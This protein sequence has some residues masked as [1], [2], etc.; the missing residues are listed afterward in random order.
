MIVTIEIT[1]VQPQ[2]VLGIAFKS[3]VTDTDMDDLN[4]WELVFTALVSNLTD[5]GVNQEQMHYAVDN[6][7]ESFKIDDELEK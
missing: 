5:L 2:G 4:D 7:G 6:F 1:D 3:E